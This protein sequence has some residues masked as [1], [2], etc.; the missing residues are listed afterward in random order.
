M[1]NAKG[2]RWTLVFDGEGDFLHVEKNGAR[3]AESKYPISDVA[4]IEGTY[5]IEVVRFRTKDGYLAFRFHHPDCR[6]FP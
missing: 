4:T 1:A 5:A 6:T 3:V 2:D